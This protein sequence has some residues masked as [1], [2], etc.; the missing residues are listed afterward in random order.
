MASGITAKLLHVDLTT[1][2]TRVEEVPETILR[3]H[4]GG[5]AMAA[6]LLLRELKPGI[7]PLGP[8]NVLVF[9]TSVINGLSL[10]GTNRYTAAAKSP[11]TG[12]YGE[13]EAG[14]WWGPELRAAGWDGVVVHGKADRPTYLWI[15]DDKVEFRDASR[16]WGQLSGEVQDGIEAELGDKRVRVLQCGV[17][18]ERGVRFAAI[19]N[20]LKH[21]HGR[22]GLGAVM[23]SKNLKAIAVRG[24]KP[25]AATDKDAAKQKLVWFKDHY[26]R[27]KDRFHQL[28]SSSGVLALEASG[29]LPTR[30]FRD[31]SFEGARDISGQKMRDTILV[32]R[33]T[34]YACA[35]ACKREVEVKELGVTPRYGGPEYETLAATGS[36][37]GI[38]DLNALALINQLY[39]QY[40]LDSISTG[41]VIAFA[42]ECYEQGIVDKKATGGLDLTWGNAEDT[43][44]LIHQIGR[45]EGFG[46][47]L[48]EG[49]KRAAAQLGKGAEKFALHV[50]GQELPMHDPRGKKG[51]SLAY[52]L[53]PTGADHMEAP[54]DP[55]Y[56]GFHTQGHP[57]GVLGL[58]E[59]LDPL[60]LDA[61]K[62]RAFFE[63]QKVWSFYNSVGMCDFVG[64]PLN[65]MELTPLVD[66]VNG[67][68]G[69]NMSLYE[70]MKVG[71]RANTL[72]RVFNVREGFTVNDDVLPQR[73]HE[74]IGN[75]V[76]KGSRVEPDKFFAAR[77]TYYEMAGWDPETG[78][79][80]ASKLAELG[81]TDVTV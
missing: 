21:F 76:L 58:I 50:K 23:G 7:D 67:V 59:P 70:A 77:R 56:A 72:A 14:G 57:M 31:G 36:L 55:L 30:N 66:Y 71:E 68:T 12:G 38:N 9:M 61:K 4:L 81:L 65:V 49:V 48:G 69:W 27:E 44:K 25:P 74:G 16:H 11:L 13:S 62:V 17:S 22:S 24:S 41:A 20:Q 35:V 73:L 80:T 64:A 29:I 6:W 19:V 60:D 79:P 26:D 53:S 33:G 15:K 2:Q 47:L 5:G 28:G 52:A 34:C 78:K 10:S 32:N 40:V 1:R 46:T 75:G 42:M 45:R 37:C 43:I 3:R 8:D 51:L 39:A 18:G 63:T 54:H